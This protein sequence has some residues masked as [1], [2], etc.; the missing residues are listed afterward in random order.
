MN[1]AIYYPLECTD[2]NDIPTQKEQKILLGEY[3]KT[4]GWKIAKEYKEQSKREPN[5]KYEELKKDS[6]S[7]QFDFVLVYSVHHFGRHPLSAIDLLEN[8]F[9]P[10]G[11]GFCFFD[12]KYDSSQFSYDEN[13]KYLK[14]LKTNLALSLR[15]E[16]LK[17]QRFRRNYQQYGYLF[18]EDETGK[19]LVIDPEASEVVKT[20]FQMFANGTTRA[21]ITKYL[22]DN[23]IPNPIQHYVALGLTNRKVRVTKW[24]L[25]VV[26]NIIANKTYYGVYR[27]NFMDESILMDAPVFIDL[28]VLQ[29]VKDILKWEEEHPS[30]FAGNGGENAFARLLFDKQTGNRFMSYGRSR[31]VDFCLKTVIAE[32]T[33]SLVYSDEKIMFK[34]AVKEAQRVLLAEHKM[35]CNAKKFLLSAQGKKAVEHHF[36]EL[37]KIRV[38]YLEE[39]I[40]LIHL[41]TKRRIEKRVDSDN[42]S[43]KIEVLDNKAIEIET[44]IKK[45][46]EALNENNPWIVLFSQQDF[47]RDVASMKYRK[48]AARFE[49]I[50]FQWLELIPKNNEWK[51]LIPVEWRSEL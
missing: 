5:L 42:F 43:H 50:D 14:D 35:A 27:Q 22:N 41:D 20:M 6:Y 39:L 15:M 46:K 16:G 17:Q 26:T 45:T 44:K 36:E 3:V 4:K 25:G 28:D 47:K 7:R 33:T 49:C 8:I 11:I 51:E 38:G 9:L 19:K 32:K 30:G 23:R 10:A 18:Q 34:D 1:C 21:G 48:Y 2:S 29:K 37:Q 12:C 13:A 24:S 40:L 31:T